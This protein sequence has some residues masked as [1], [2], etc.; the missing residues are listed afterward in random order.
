MNN[1]F[2]AVM[3]DSHNNVQRVEDAVRYCRDKHVSRIVHCGDFC[4]PEC[5]AFFRDI[6]TRFAMGNND[7]FRNTLISTIASIGGEYYILE[8]VFEWNSKLFYFAHGDYREE[9][10][11]AFRSQRYDFILCGHTH[12]FLCMRFGRTIALNPGA[13]QQGSFCLINSWGNVCRVVN[14]L[15]S[16]V[17]V[18][19]APD[20]ETLFSAV[21]DMTGRERALV[22]GT[23]HSGTGS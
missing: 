3:A 12:K 6:P 20:E 18:E 19:V 5:I 11:Q 16:Q 14:G 4:E 9:V 21:F 22:F 10:C 17:E 8:G 15:T 23:D 7:L 2:I 13:L 1:K